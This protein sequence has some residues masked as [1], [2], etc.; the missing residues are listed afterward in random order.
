[1]FRVLLATI[2]ITAVVSASAQ[3]NPTPWDQRPSPH[4]SHEYVVD[5]T[6]ITVEYGRPFKRGRMIWGGLRPWGEWGM[7]GADEATTVITTD[8]LRFG[9]LVMPAGEHTLYM[10]PDQKAPKLIIN[11][12][13]GQFHTVYHSNRDLGRVD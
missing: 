9:D 3:R 7:P 8:A 5:G 11:N 10:M 1:M 6:K 12:E 13:T 2:L 4:E